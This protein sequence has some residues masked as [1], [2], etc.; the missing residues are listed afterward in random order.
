MPPL[1][2]DPDFSPA[3]NMRRSD[4][5]ARFAHVAF[6]MLNDNYLPGTLTAGY[7]LRRQ[8]TQA[9]LVCLVTPEISTAARSA[10]ARIYDHVLETEEIYVPHTRR[11]ERQ[12]RPYYFTRLNT[13]RLGMDGDLGLHY[14]K[15]VV[16]D[17]DVLPM[18]HFDHL[19]TVDAPGGIINENKAHFVETDATGKYIFPPKS[20]ILED[21][22]GTRSMQLVPM[23]TPFPSI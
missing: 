13:L 17:S 9:D 1:Q 6:L 11:Q 5:S 15:I 12:D 19:F 21:G 2:P 8:Q 18:R 4:G 23:G 16:L 7:G 10:L 14:E 20:K 22:I 3:T